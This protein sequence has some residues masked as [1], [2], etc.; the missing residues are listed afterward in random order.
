MVNESADG[1]ELL[2]KPDYLLTTL[3]SSLFTLPAAVRLHRCS[4]EVSIGLF[5]LLASYDSIPKPF[6]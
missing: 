4:G 1:P 5:L 2:L 3:P 6:P